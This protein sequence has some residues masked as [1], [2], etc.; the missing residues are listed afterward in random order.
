ME[1]A[2]TTCPFCSCGCAVYL[3]AHEGRPA[4]SAPSVHHPVSGGKLCARGW[5]AHEAPTWGERLTRP[6][7]RRRGVQE[8]TTW[9]DALRQAS[10]ALAAL[11]MS[12]RKVG[13]LGSARASNEENYLAARLARGA[14]TSGNVD[15]CLRATY[16][17]IVDGIASVLGTGP[18]GRFADLDASE[19]ILVLEHD[20]AVT[21][22][23]AAH[24]VIRAVKAG[25]TLV[26]VGS[27]RTQLARL[28]SLHLPSRPGERAAIIAELAAAII[29]EGEHAGGAGIEQLR[30]SVAGLSAGEAIRN[31]ASRLARAASVSV[32]IAPE[33]GG[34][35]HAAD[36]GSAVAT[37]AALA[38]GPGRQAWALMVLPARGNLRGACEMGV[39]PDRLPGGAGLDDATAARLTQAWGRS[40]SRAAGMPAADL[41]SEAS[42]LVV[43]AS[44]PTAVLPTGWA[45]LDAMTAS[46][47]LV[48]LDAFA[49][50][51]ARAAQVVLPIASFAESEGTVTSAEGRVQRLHPVGTPPGDARPGW[52]VL[53]ELSAALGLAHAYGSATDVLREIGAAIP[54]YSGVPEEVAVEPWGTFTAPSGARARVL[55]P[56]PT[57]RAAVAAP[58]VLALDGVFDWGSDPLVHFSPTLSRD[59][60]SQCKLYPRGL[61]QLGRGDAKTLGVRD[62]W[63][64]RLVSAHGE[65]VLPAVLRD[66]LEPGVLL[67]PYAFRESAD[68]VLAGRSQVPVRAEK[69]E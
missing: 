65:A 45:A 8:P 30:R 15:S 9:G 5:N 16:L 35:E 37:L 40:P 34:A 42:G 6:A 51:T 64:V 55:R 28:A 38:E 18:T 33:G 17:P 13:V 24:A 67:V 4:A 59:H 26:T 69:A 48:V 25:R 43:V 50:P 63:P 10:S 60:L 52:L 22:P 49:T 47:C 11:S 14:L 57:A 54:Q 68:A 20:I 46:E 12:D 61:V 36:E 58:A 41:V 44:D 23:Q 19:A 29:N 1:R 27:T 32:L 31:A 39:A 3:R 53:A 2:I 7:V 56:F 66:D 62:G 21:H